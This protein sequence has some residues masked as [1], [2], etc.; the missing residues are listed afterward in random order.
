MIVW[1]H[2][3]KCFLK[4]G[5]IHNLYGL[6]RHIRFQKKPISLSYYDRIL[7][8]AAPP[9]QK[10]SVLIAGKKISYPDAYWFLHSFDE[11]FEAETYRFSPSSEKPLIIDC[12][13]NI[14]LSI[15]YF[16][17]TYP[18][19]HIIAFEPDPEIFSI[20]TENLSRFDFSNVE[21][22]QM[23]VWTDN[24]ELNFETDGTLGGRLI[25]TASASQPGI[26]K[27]KTKDLKTLL[28][29]QTVDFLKMD[30]EG[31]EY[32][33]LKDC[34]AY[35]PNVRNIFVEYH[36]YAKRKQCLDEMLSI[37][38]RAGFRY[39]IRNAKNDSLNP[40]TQKNW[41]HTFDLQLNIFG[42][43]LTDNSQIV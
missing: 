32:E 35:L 27:V 20:Q 30:I 36:S 42:Y 34:S 12:G 13:A 17:L 29:N 26:V 22:H 14:G 43:R 28:S 9:K 33:V 24:T 31:A 11:I 23:A 19:A 21:T 41:Y 38:S 10:G 3:I 39:Y 1:V 4:T 8:T 6:Y 2:F 16:K 40:Y 5:L 25:H 7:L 18:H 15:I 37:L